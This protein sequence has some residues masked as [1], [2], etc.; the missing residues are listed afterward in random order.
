MPVIVVGADTPSGRE[1]A[2]TLLSRGGEVRCFVTDPAAGASLRAQGAKV[3]IGDLSDRSHVGAAASNAF[4]AVLLET[5][6][7]DDRPMSFADE[8]TEVVAA[9]AAALQEA[10]VQRV[11]WVGSHPSAAIS[12]RAIEFA[13]VAT[14]GRTYQ[15]VAQEVA[16]LNDR[17]KLASKP[18][19]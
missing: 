11:I 3:A 4:T 15:D 10:G 6:A 13:V 17:K 18:G 8:P 1:I 12:G 19:T 5:A 2:A 16:D 7:L 9:W 14:D